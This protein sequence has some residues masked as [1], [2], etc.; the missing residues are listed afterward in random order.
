MVRMAHEEKSLGVP[1]VAHWVKNLTAAA[2]VAQRRG[3]DPRLAQWVQRSSMG[4]SVAL[5]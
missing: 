5:I 2:R 3:F 4:A 1:A